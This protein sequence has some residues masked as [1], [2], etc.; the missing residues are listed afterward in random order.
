M[1]T[2]VLRGRLLGADDIGF[3][4]NSIV[5]SNY[6]GVTQSIAQV[7]AS[8]IPLLAQ[9]NTVEDLFDGGQDVSIY[10]DKIAA[11][12]TCY[13]GGA[14]EVDST[15]DVT[16]NTTL[17][18]TLT[19]PLLNVAGFVK[20]TAAGL[21]TGGNSVVL[22]VTDVPSDVITGAAAYAASSTGTDNYAIALTP[23]IAAYKDGQ[24]IAFKADVANVGFA[25]INV[26][27]RGVRA[28][29]KY[30]SGSIISLEDNDIVAG[31]IA[32]ILYNA[33]ASTFILLNPSQSIGSY[34]NVYTTPGAYVWTRAP[35]IRRALVY[36]CAGGGGGGYGAAAPGGNTGGGG[37]CAGTAFGLYDVSAVT[38]VNVTIGAGG[39]GGTIGLTTGGTGGTSSFG[40]FVSALGG[41]GGTSANPGVA[42]NGN[43]GVGG[44]I[45]NAWG[46]NGYPGG[47]AGGSGGNGG[48][49]SY[50]LI[51]AYGGTGST[52]AGATAGTPFAA[53]G[54]GGDGGTVG[55]CNGAAGAPGFC[56]I[57]AVSTGYP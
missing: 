9:A 18:G 4:R 32:L 29:S 27:G 50:S 11:K 10:P 3:G 47:A 12:G 19:I 54:G 15:L 41:F 35:N 57:I 1:T 13:F 46:G 16:G 40:A 56:L 31:Q 53:G 17:D 43:V 28:I 49:F 6:L 39:A 52:G 23:P 34:V 33:T 14:T 26:D 30:M 20:N 2:I 8:H 24:L 37:G 48:N 21:I 45:F 42:G 55:G 44:S 36:V 7:N 22:A 38:T 25:T 51:P 5:Y